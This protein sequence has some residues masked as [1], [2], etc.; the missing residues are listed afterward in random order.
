MGYDPAWL[1]V[2]EKMPV[3]VLNVR[4]GTDPVRVQFSL[5]IPPT[6]CEALAPPIAWKWKEYGLP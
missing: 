4:P 3:V 1:G 6:D 5:A 2:P